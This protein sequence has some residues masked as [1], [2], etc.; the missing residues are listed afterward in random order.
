M[1][2]IVELH[3]IAPLVT[4]GVHPETSVNVPS[5]AFNLEVYLSML[6]AQVGVPYKVIEPL[7]F[8]GC[9]TKLEVNK[10]FFEEIYPRIRDNVSI[11]LP[12]NVRKV[13][14]GLR[15]GGLFKRKDLQEAEKMVSTR[16]AMAEESERGY[17]ARL[18]ALAEAHAEYN[19]VI[20]FD[21]M[22]ALE[23]SLGKA[24]AR[25]EWQVKEA[26]RQSVTL[27]TCHEVTCTFQPANEPERSLNM[28]KY[29]VQIDFA[30]N[31][32]LVKGGKYNVQ[33]NIH[34]HVSGSGSPCMGNAKE[35]LSNLWITYDVDAFLR[36]LLLV[37]RNYNDE[38]PYEPFSKF[39]D[40]S[41]AAQ[42][43]NTASLNEFYSAVDSLYAANFLTRGQS[44]IELVGIV[45]ASG[46]IPAA[47]PEITG[48]L[49]EKLYPYEDSGCLV[50]VFRTAVTGLV[51]ML[52]P[53]KCNG[54]ERSWYIYNRNTCVY[55]VP[56]LSEQLLNVVVSSPQLEEMEYA[57]HYSDE[58]E[59]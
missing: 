12:E 19:R 10:K 21:A 38:S 1:E 37:L 14:G 11:M 36:A 57:E 13:L 27:E 46:D 33:G 25:G 59:E 9:E 51:Y 6:C 17:M 52:S 58:D 40:K 49:R 50:P 31:K 28:G 48:E 26:T 5:R 35:T 18:R 22:E 4:P 20:M 2:N 56:L 3:P 30:A 34:P 42:A 55:L 54:A 15:A 23:E 29:A 16:K 53:T 24:L 7:A 8:T 44:D 32:L 41:K 47:I 43:S 39:E 45:H